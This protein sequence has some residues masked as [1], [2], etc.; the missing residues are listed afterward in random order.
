MLPP[1]LT[2]TDWLDLA[3]PDLVWPAACLALA[4]AA[5]RLLRALEAARREARWDRGLPPR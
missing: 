1:E 2:M 4:A 5:W 3:T